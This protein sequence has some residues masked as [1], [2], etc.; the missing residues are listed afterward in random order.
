MST[1]YLYVQVAELDNDLRKERLFEIPRKLKLHRLS[2]LES[3]PKPWHYEFWDTQP[4]PDTLPFTLCH[5]SEDSKLVGKSIDD[6]I[7]EKKETSEKEDHE[8]SSEWEWEYYDDSDDDQE[9][10][11]GGKEDNQK[12][13]EK[14]SVDCAVGSARQWREM[15]VKLWE[16]SIVIDDEDDESEEGEAEKLPK[17]TKAFEPTLVRVLLLFSGLKSDHGSKLFSQ[18]RHLRLICWKVKPWMAK[19][20]SKMFSSQFAMLWNVDVDEVHPNL[21]IGDQATA[22]NIKVR[23]L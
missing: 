10:R 15:S 22:K 4:D 19:K 8:S 11:E 7:E 17:P 12:A 16:G 6:P 1:F 2:D 14:V 5:M 20:S 18:E 13:V 23:P 21:Y 9:E 3:L